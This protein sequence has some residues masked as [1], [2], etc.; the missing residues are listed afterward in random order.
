M[1]SEGKA[2]TAKPKP[3]EERGSGVKVS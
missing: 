1:G 2:R 3:P